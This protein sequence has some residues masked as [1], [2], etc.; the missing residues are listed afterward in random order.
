M[1]NV[2]R[3]WLYS[4]GQQ[5]N[6][7]FQ[8]ISHVEEFVT[9][10][11]QHQEKRVHLSNGQI[12]TVRLATITDAIDIFEVE[13][14]AYN[15]NPP[16]QQE[17][18]VE[19]L[20]Y[21]PRAIYTVMT[22]EDRIVAFIGSR[23]TDLDVHITNVAVHSDYRFLG[24]ATIL[25]KQIEQYARQLEKNWLT[26]EVRQSNTKAIRLYQKFGFMI[27]GY[28]KQYY[29][30]EKE[31]AIEMNYVL[32]PKTPSS[33]NSAEFSF[34]RLS[35]SPENAERLNVLTQENYE[36]APHWSAQT[37]LE[38]L[39][40]SHSY[41]YG[42]YHAGQ[43]IGFV[44]LQ[45]VLDEATITNIVICK[46]FQGQ[47]LAQRLWQMSSYDLQQQ[48]VTVVF[49]EVREF[50]ER[51]QQLYEILGF[52]QYHRRRDYYTDPLEDAILYRL[53]VEKGADE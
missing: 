31:D 32:P 19:D 13:A 12:A 30:P 40:Q 48:A 25:M 49:L 33:F 42:V 43:L 27:S 50:N 15:G 6:I 39:E 20:Q 45:I 7:T 23:V 38:D 18:F 4:L 53:S 10:Q 36:Y 46:E 21:N 37:F 17:A 41:Y 16:W 14:E 9:S 35:A 29:K 24:C 52:E 44:G 1:W 2:C 34:Q 5:M 26:L 28:K 11:L 8:R 47:G 3:E 51:A 22:V